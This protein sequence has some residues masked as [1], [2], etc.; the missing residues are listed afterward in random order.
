LRKRR[1]RKKKRALWDGRYKPY[2][3]ITSL[4][5]YNEDKQMDVETFTKN[6]W[7]FLD[8]CEIE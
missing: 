4:D 7:G 5:Q 6:W 3:V 1:Y 8:I 2:Y